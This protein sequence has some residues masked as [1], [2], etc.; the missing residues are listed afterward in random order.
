M[1][2]MRDFSAKLSSHH[3]AKV[4]GSAGGS[5]WDPRYAL[6]R[7]LLLKYLQV[8]VL[9]SGN[10]LV[11]TLGLLGS[12]YAG[13]LLRSPCVSRKAST[14]LLSQ[15]AWADGLVLLHRGLGVLQ[16]QAGGP[17]EGLR[18]G[19]LTA[20]EHASVLLLSCLSLEAFLVILRP[21]ESRAL[22]TAHSAQLA[23]TA[24]WA[25]VLGELA[26]LQAAGSGFHGDEGSVLSL[27]LQI[28]LQ[29]APL[30]RLLSRGLG[31]FLWLS[32]AYIYYA[33]YNHSHLRRKGNFH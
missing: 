29:V 16:G 28:C 24:I 4:R 3:Q 19:L 12:L 2:L 6:K 33:L 22:R 11:S 30:L 8:L 31:G 15:L 7:Y 21:V 25:A 10:G 18:R 32:N 17:L 20:N 1:E 5:Q 9:P 14:V 26:T 27:V 23:C 13:L